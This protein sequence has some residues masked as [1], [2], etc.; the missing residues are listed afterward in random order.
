M[1]PKNRRR[2]SKRSRDNVRAPL[3]VTH[4]TIY[5]QRLPA[6]QLAAAAGVLA[7]YENRIF[8][9]SGGLIAFGPTYVDRT[10]K[11]A[12]SGDLPVAQPTT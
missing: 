11:S 9:D 7:I 6:G 8:A 2:S 3:V 10:L 1:V 12:R 5:N 4:S